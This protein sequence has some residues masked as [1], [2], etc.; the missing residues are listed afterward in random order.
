MLSIADRERQAKMNDQ[1]ETPTPATEATPAALPIPATMPP[2]IS[3]A[4]AKRESPHYVLT[5][6]P[7]RRRGRP[8]V[9]VT[10]GKTQLMT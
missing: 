8:W 9:R 6:Q 2:R 4:R 10:C 1:N 7:K 3:F 5:L